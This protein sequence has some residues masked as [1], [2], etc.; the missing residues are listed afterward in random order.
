MRLACAGNRGGLKVLVPRTV[1]GMHR[2][3]HKIHLHMP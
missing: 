1:K 3:Y 2:M